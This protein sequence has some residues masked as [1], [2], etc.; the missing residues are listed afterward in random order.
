MHELG[1]PAR[2]A[3]APTATPVK[4]VGQACG[5]NIGLLTFVFYSRSHLDLVDLVMAMT[6]I[7]C[8]LVDSYVVWREGNL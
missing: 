6:G 4:V 8:G 5:T 7:Y 2:I 1:F 3:D